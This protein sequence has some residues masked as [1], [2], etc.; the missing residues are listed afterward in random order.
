MPLKN[1]LHL[2][3]SQQTTK[4]RMSEGSCGNPFLCGNDNGKLFALRSKANNCFLDVNIG[5]SF[6]GL[7][8]VKLLAS[9]LHLV[10]IS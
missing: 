2:T 9:H 3:Q 10:H 1:Y 4:A 5:V 6:I 8:I 7:C